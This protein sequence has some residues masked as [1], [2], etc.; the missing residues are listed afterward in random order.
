MRFYRALLFLYP[1]RFREEYR[2]ELS[3]AFA[4]RM[5]GRSALAGLLAAIADVVPNAVA[6]H[7]DVL[8]HEVAS[9][10]AWP[11]FGSD[12]RFAVRQ[13]RST[14]LFSGVVIGVIALGI[15]I[16][17]GMLTLLNAYAWRPAPGIPPDDRLARLNPMAA[18]GRDNHV[19]EVTLSYAEVQQLRAQRT[20]FVDV[21]AWQP[22][23]LGVDLGG[24]AESVVVAYASDNYFRTLRVPMVAGGGFPDGAERTAAPIAVIGHS[25]WMT[26]FGGSRDAIGKTI[27]VMNLPFTIVGVAPPRFVG[28][29]SD[30]LG[31][32]AIWIPLG[33]QAMLEPGS[34]TRP[35]SPRLRVFAR[36]ARGVDDGDVAG[37]TGPL[38]AQ[39]AQQNPERNAR[40][41][42]RAEPLFGMPPSESGTKE[43][44]AAFFIVIT[45]VVIITCTNVSALLLG[46]AV[47]RRREIGVRLSL[48]ATRFRVIRQMLT[49]SFVYAAAGALLAMAL[50]VVAM[51]IT[52]AAIP[53]L[54]PGLE[55]SAPTFVFAAIFALATTIVFGIAP[56]LHATSADIAQVMKNSG[57]HAIRR[58]R[59]QAT[60]VVIQLACSQPVLVVT[61]LVLADIRRSMQTDA[62]KAPASVV[63]MRSEL[64]RPMGASRAASAA[65]DSNALSIRGTFTLI[66]GRIEQIPGVASAGMS[67]AAAG[68][69]ARFETRH[70][71]DTASR[72]VTQA[73]EV[74][75][76]PDYFS[77]VGVPIVRG[78]PIS[79]D[80]DQRGTPVVVVNQEVAQLLWPGEDPIGK[81]LYR[82]TRDTETEA[83]AL[84]VIG[85]AGRPAYDE[86][87]RRPE[88][89]APLANDPAMW[90][91]AAGD[92]SSSE[93]RFIA[94]PT[95]AVRTTDDAR[96]L[97]PQIRT[98]IREIDPFVAIRDVRTIAE[99]YASRKREAIQG[100]LA[101]FAIGAV[102]LAL[103]SLGLYA[104]VAFAVEQRTREIGIRIA[105]GATP[106]GV[107][108]QFLRSGVL[109]SAIGL[110]IGLPVTVAAIRVVE[111]SLIGFTP[112]GVG[113]VMLVVPVL[114]G[115]AVLASWLPARRAGRVDPLIA[116]RSE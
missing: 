78:R 12:L 14:P 42:L 77:T 64:F 82:R 86:S 105:M 47:A 54:I 17:A 36:L 76:T 28:V 5:R 2:D 106:G 29:E 7:W 101:A 34:P 71:S 65:R 9:G 63:T 103:A 107:V 102:A 61:S 49:E 62:D 97:V 22:T 45:L 38:A 23:N 60:F 111:A 11:A 94:L 6:A 50:Y 89:F 96:D 83:L 3:R 35:N 44:I 26:S 18:R 53:E 72:H 99:Q 98:A 58:S 108:R 75:V 79:R 92:F 32:A 81:R 13:I 20:V 84:E 59:L 43:L 85:V 51:R 41:V 95:I 104:I 70:A 39:L 73:R 24:G 33:A 55:P 21:A 93:V 90:P 4:E 15:G 31:R 113:T 116:L 30:N 115:V 16:N 10:L 37:R 52:Y 56:A 110:A 67:H 80:D 1:S 88:I 48:G 87:E 8:R 27:R 100:N 112:E 74:Y 46:R 19:S 57:T 91:P 114:I 69:A 66:R 25:I 109:L 40:F 68:S